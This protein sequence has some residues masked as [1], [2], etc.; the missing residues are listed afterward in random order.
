MKTKSQPGAILDLQTLSTK[1]IQK[2]SQRHIA[3]FQIVPWSL[4]MPSMSR[5]QAHKLTTSKYF[6]RLYILAGLRRHTL[7]TAWNKHHASESLSPLRLYKVSTELLYIISLSIF[8]V[9]RFNTINSQYTKVK[10]NFCRRPA[11]QPLW[12]KH[13][14]QG[15]APIARV[16][17]GLCPPRGPRAEGKEL[18]R[19]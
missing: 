17:W 13:M 10:R 4:L 8:K 3:F 15:R 9:W 19:G 18:R 16:L 6:L 12:H 11:S 1:S 7:K 2:A 5:Q 14:W